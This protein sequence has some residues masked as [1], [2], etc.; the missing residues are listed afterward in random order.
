MVGVMVKDPVCVIGI[1]VGKNKQIFVP[2]LILL[3]LLE[4]ELME[5]LNKT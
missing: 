4:L 2:N 5:C 3:Q 1:I